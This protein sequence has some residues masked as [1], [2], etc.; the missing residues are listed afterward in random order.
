[1][2]QQM[3]TLATFERIRDR[4]AALPGVQLASIGSTAPLRKS[5][6]DLDVK[7]EGRAAAPNEP[8]PHAALKTIDSELF[9]GGRAFRCSRG[10]RFASADRARRRRR[11]SIVSKALARAVVRQRESDRPSRRVDGRDA[12]SSAV[13]RRLAHGRRRRRRHA[14]R[15]LDGE[16]TPTMFEP[17][18]QELLIGGALV[19]RTTAD[20]ALL[21]ARRSSR[22]F[23]SRIRGS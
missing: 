14:R 7:A 23:A 16:P 2:Q 11:S 18:A 19:V 21:A 10:A 22:P 4:V 9:R 12:A 13:H 5:M 15:G 20:P 1:M 3:E 17:F 8:T 6:L